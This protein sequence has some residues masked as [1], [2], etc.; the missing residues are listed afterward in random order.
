M[1]F[2]IIETLKW[3]GLIFA[4]GFIGYLGKYLGKIILGKVH[5]KGPD[6]YG[7]KSD[8]TPASDMSEAGI[9]AK[10]E[11]KVEKKRLKA[12]KKRTKKQ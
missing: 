5:S 2:D 8:T 7:N 10:Y 11:Y 6:A 12:E 3:V 9:K 4:A 1:E